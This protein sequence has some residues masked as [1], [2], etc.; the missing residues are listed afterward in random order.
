MLD[1]NFRYGSLN[2]Y[3]SRKREIEKKLRAKN[4]FALE[5]QV[6]NKEKM[7]EKELMLTGRKTALK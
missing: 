6:I 2:N 4:K 5:M 1:Y 3:V 7:I